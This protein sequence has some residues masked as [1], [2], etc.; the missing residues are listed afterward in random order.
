VDSGAYKV[1]EKMTFEKLVDEW[2]KRYAEDELKPKTR[3]GYEYELKFR[4]MPEFRHKQL[5][6]IKTK[7]L[8]DFFSDLKKPGIRVANKEKPLSPSTV[9]YVYKVVKCIL[10][11]LLD[12]E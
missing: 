10:I 2:R 6:E 3:Y 12:G 9:L 5:I 11:E 4:I 7:H 8:V 1:P